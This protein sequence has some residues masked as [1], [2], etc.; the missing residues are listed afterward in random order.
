MTNIRRLLQR[1][2][3]ID[4]V[5]VLAGSAACLG[6]VGYFK[7]D[8][9]QPARLDADHLFLLTSAK[10][11]ING[12]GFR[13]DAQLGYPDVR[14]NLYFPGFDLSYRVFLWLATRFTQ[15]P[16]LAVHALY[17]AGLS[18]M[19]GFAY[20]ALKRLDIRTWLAA[21][22]ALSYVLTPFLARRIYSHDLLTLSFAVPLGFGLALMVGTGRP[23]G[24][25]KTFL[26]DP[27]TIATI[28][29]VGSSGLYYA[30]YTLMFLAFAGVAASVGQ[31]R[32]FP[33]L[34]AACAGAPLFLLLIYSG[35][36]L[37]L[38]VA[39]GSRYSGPHRFAYEQIMY[40]LDLPSMAYPFQRLHKVAEGVAQTNAALPKGPILFE[41]EGEWPAIPLMLALLGAPLVAAMCQG[42]NQAGEAVAGHVRLLGFCALC[43][44]FAIL[45]GARGGLGYI[46]NLLF[47]PEIRADGRL[48]P[49]LN[50]AAIV[51]LCAGAELLAKTGSRWLGYAGL[52]VVAS[53]LLVSIKPAIGAAVR[54]EHFYMDGPLE[55]RLQ[56]STPAMVAA[57]NRAGLR[58]VL[59]LP[60]V[61]WPES[62]FVQILDPYEHQL[63]YIY[64]TP[65]NPTRWSYGANDKQPWFGV[66]SLATRDPQTLVA[67]ARSLG[68][69]SV[70]IQK[71][72]L[73]PAKLAATQAAL[74]AQLA[75]EC[76]VFEDEVEVLYALRTSPNGRA[77]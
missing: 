65:G 58:T 7:L 35:Y 66:V 11:L 45:F 21:I 24:N 77:C 6:L 67:H 50:F 41:G 16:F 2:P 76:K 75:T 49:F 68:F 5:I 34:A 37:D 48:M 74:A 59:E 55:K 8:W 25:L 60:T 51:T 3:L 23:E 53:L 57:K 19:Y 73:E 70:L 22:G 4:W 29:I 63:P 39:L 42:A 38:L 14:D 28:V 72:G 40:G 62:P 15:N 30:F 44:V 18:A 71:R 32:W 20:W 56:A 52:A 69:D 54:V 61:N 13:L 12:H 1:V 26:R 27:F 9:T 31:R 64:D 43:I 46:F 33:L 10:S 17:I 36:G 47:T